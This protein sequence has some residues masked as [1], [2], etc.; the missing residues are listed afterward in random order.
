MTYKYGLSSL[1][2]VNINRGNTSASNNSTPFKII[3]VRVTDIILDETHPQFSSFGEW[4]SIGLV[5][6][7]FVN[8]KKSSQIDWSKRAQPLFANVKNYPLINEVI[9][10]FT[11]PNVYNI[12][13]IASS[14]LNYYINAINLFNNPSNDAIPNELL[15]NTLGTELNASN[16]DSPENDNSYTG[17]INLGKTFEDNPN[18]RSLVPYEGDYIIEGRFGNSIRFG[19]TVNVNGN[20]YNPWSQDGKN[21]DPILILRSGQKPIINTSD[22]SDITEDI[23]E[24]KSSIYLASN[25]KIPLT[26]SS[27]NYNSYTTAPESISK[28]KGEQIILNSGR[29]VFN[30]KSD[31]I[32][33][34]SL[35]SINLNSKES[36]NIDSPSTVINSST[37][38]LG[39]KEANEPILLGNSTVILLESLITNLQAFTEVCAT[40][41]YG[42]EGTPIAPLNTVSLQLSQVLNELNNQLPKI[43]SQTSFT[44]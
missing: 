6:W 1:N 5:A 10:L 7:E 33:L 19:S 22:F 9:Y 44:K 11:L 16:F 36:V 12:N 15:V 3:A 8:R 38:K 39:S 24:D 43:K 35:K 21:G 30:S 31:S 29:L 13:E 32:L 27:E 23:N 20:S 34:S 2:R 40:L 41:V 14:N 4:N 42:V 37:V 18:I 28:Y 17:N 26:P 25:Q